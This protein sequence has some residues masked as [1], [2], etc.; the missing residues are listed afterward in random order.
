MRPTLLLFAV[1]VLLSLASTPAVAQSVTSANA[2]SEFAGDAAAVLRPDGSPANAWGVPSTQ[3]RWVESQAVCY[4]MRTYVA[5][6]EAP[7]SDSTR[8]AGYHE[9]LPS[10]KLEMRT[11]E[12]KGKNT[13][14]PKP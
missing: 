8:V 12:L 2:K 11:S 6:R 5:V 1:V 13:E 3:R 9:C 4:T 7:D 14:T 10:W